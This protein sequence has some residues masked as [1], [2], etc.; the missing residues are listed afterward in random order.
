M[1]KDLRSRDFGRYALEVP[2]A[3]FWPRCGKPTSR[4]Q[5]RCPTLAVE[6]KSRLGKAVDNDYWQDRLDEVPAVKS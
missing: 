5:A 6:L 1:F 3:M 4:R 2:C